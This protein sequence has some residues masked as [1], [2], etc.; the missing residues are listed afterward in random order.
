MSTETEIAAVA[1][2]LRSTPG[3]EPLAE[4]GRVLADEWLDR[5]AARAPRRP[6]D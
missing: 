1:V 3:D 4:L 2:A 5:R 6:D